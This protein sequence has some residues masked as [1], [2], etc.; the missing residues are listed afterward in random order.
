MII[1]V[2][3]PPGA[4]KDHCADYLVKKHSF[5]HITFKDSLFCDTAKHFGVSLEWL[6]RNYQDREWKETPNLKLDGYSPR[7]ALI[8]VSENIMKP[9]YGL[10]VYGRRTA[11]KILAGNYTNGVV[12]DCGFVE[13]AIE[14][15]NVLSATH[16][17]FMIQLFR[18]GCSYE[19]DSR[20]FIRAQPVVETKILNYDT[21]SGDYFSSTSLDIPCYQIHNNGTVLQFEEA[22]TDILNKQK[23]EKNERTKNRRNS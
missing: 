11:E 21:E 9:A 14:V 7:Q 23:K 19:H 8:H 16:H 3:G 22:I 4:G 18:N 2:N 10:G 12:S 13:E 6:Q 15:M 17:I 5:T 1:L 20:R